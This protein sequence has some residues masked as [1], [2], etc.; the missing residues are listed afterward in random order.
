[1]RSL[2]FLS[3][4]SIIIYTSIAC[5]SGSSNPIS[6]KKWKVD[7]EA[8]FNATLNNLPADKRKYILSDGKEIIKNQKDEMA[9][10]R[11]E[12]KID[13]TYII[14]GTGNDEKGKWKLS[15]DKNILTTTNEKGTE[16]KLK[17][18]ELSKNKFVLE[19]GEGV[20]K[21][22]IFLIPA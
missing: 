16:Q 11:M 19:A 22:T 12:F 10:T 3:Y 6:D 14:S 9:K 8:T 2:K 18:I 15:E 5:Q 7:P 13:G 1:M 17:I 20:S 21:F 4:L